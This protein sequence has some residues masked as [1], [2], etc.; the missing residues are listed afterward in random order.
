MRV[1]ADH[2]RVRRRHRAV[3]RRHRVRVSGRGHD[4]TAFQMRPGV[5]HQ[6]VR[7][8]HVLQRVEPQVARADRVVVQQIRAERAA[9]NVVCSFQKR[10]TGCFPRVLHM[11]RHVALQPH[12]H[13]GLRFHHLGRAF[14][15]TGGVRA[16][17]QRNLLR[18]D[19]LLQQIERRRDRVFAVRALSHHHRQRRKRQPGQHHAREGVELILRRQRAFKTGCGQCFD[20]LGLLRSGVDGVRG[21]C[22]GHACACM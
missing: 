10:V 15:G 17:L 12:E 11:C 2:I 19:G 13:R 7:F 1:K 16:A 4:E 8:R 14:R 5:V 21:V 3:E 18:H 6:R 20:A 9:I 22:D